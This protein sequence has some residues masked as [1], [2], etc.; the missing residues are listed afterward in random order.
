[1][2]KECWPAV[3]YGLRRAG[4]GVALAL[5]AAAGAAQE[6]GKVVVTPLLSTTVTASGQPITLPSGPVQLTVSTFEIPPGATLPV[7]K[8]PYQRY[9]YVL[10]GTLRVTNAATGDTYDYKAGDMVVEVLDTWHSGTNTG[11][12]PLRL[13]VIDQAPPGA[14]NTTLQ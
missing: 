10:E 3:R 2:M 1:M 6:P 9:A 7:H 12:G 5:A 13:L 8:H 4:L 14:S 11:T